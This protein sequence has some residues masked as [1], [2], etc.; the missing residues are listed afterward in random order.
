MTPGCWLGN[1]LDAGAFC[2]DKERRRQ[3]G[4]SV[5][6]ETCGRCGSGQ[7]EERSEV[8]PGR[9]TAESA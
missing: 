4:F 3:N 7:L 5:E 6:N 9:Q 1:W 8:R 2:P